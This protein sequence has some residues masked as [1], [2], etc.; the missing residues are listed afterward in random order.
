MSWTPMNWLAPPKTI[1]DIAWASPAESPLSM[2]YA[3]YAM[4]NGATP[5]SNGS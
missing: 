4:P 5:S 3:P 2:A 1:A